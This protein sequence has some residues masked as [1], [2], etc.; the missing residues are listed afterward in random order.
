MLDWLRWR[1]T[2]V[3]H[4]GV[5]RVAVVVVLLLLPCTIRADN[6]HTIAIDGVFD[7][8]SS[9]TVRRDPFRASEAAASPLQGFPR[10]PDNHESFPATECAPRNA[11]WNPSSDIVDAAFT[12]DD[13]HLFGF[14]RT[15][16]SMREPRVVLSVLLDLDDDA[17]TGYCSGTAGIVP[18]MCGVDMT[19]RLMLLVRAVSLEC[20]FVVNILLFRATTQRSASHCMPSRIAAK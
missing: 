10:T 6:P 20:L 13:E 4:T 12:H 1:L 14:V 15:V 3:T 18:N 8:W 11:I 19:L 2:G 5:L 7:D 9:V 17:N 16:T